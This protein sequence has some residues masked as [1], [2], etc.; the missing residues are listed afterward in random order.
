MRVTYVLDRPELG[1]GVKVV[2]QHAQLLIEL[3]HDVRII[4]NGNQPNWI[5]FSGRYVNRTTE[6]LSLAKQDIVIATYWTTI[7]FAETLPSDI[8]MHFCQGYEGRFS[9]LESHFPQIEALYH[10]DIPTIVVQPTLAQYLETRFQRRTTVVSPPIDIQFHPLRRL[11]RQQPA[12]IV[13]QGIFEAPTKGVP[14]ALLIAQRIREIGLDCS[15]IRISTFPLSDDEKALLTPDEYHYQIPPTDVARLM[16]ASD[17]LI[18]T[19]TYEEGF[20]LPVVEAMQS[21]VPVVATDTPANHFITKGCVPLLSSEDAT[22]FAKQ[23][24]KI[25]QNPLLYHWYREVGYRMIQRFH[26]N[27]IREQLAAALDWATHLPDLG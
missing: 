10:R 7:K 3:G 20:G 26:P 8:F 9:Y 5:E 1:G 4:G 19:T 24:I 22:P 13:I 18:H 23:V 11:R 21:K 25:L 27:H 14:F 12:R 15:I 2:F 17:C 6:T 16:R